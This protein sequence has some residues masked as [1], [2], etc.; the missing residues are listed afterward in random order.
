VQGMAPS[1]SVIRIAPRRR[2]G[3]AYCFSIL[4]VPARAGSLLP[5]TLARIQ[6]AGKTMR[7]TIITLAEDVGRRQ[8]AAR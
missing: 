4:E 5:V 3:T 2:V 7:P 8:K 1:C 6:L